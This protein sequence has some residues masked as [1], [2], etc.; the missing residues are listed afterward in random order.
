MKAINTL[1]VICLMVLGSI[2]SSHS[3]TFSNE[4]ITL[5]NIDGK[6]ITL[7]SNTELHIT[8]PSSS[9]TGTINITSDSGWLF[10]EGVRPSEAIENHLSYIKVNGQPSV[11]KNNI[12]VTNFLLGCV[13]MNHAP[14]F[15]ALSAFK[16][17]NYSGEEMRFSP[18]TYYKSV[19]LG[20]FDNSISS[21]KL[22]RGYMATF[23]ENENG[24]GYSKVFI[25]DKEDIE[26]SLLQVELNNKVSFIRVFPWRYTNKKGIGSGIDFDR[27]SEPINRLNGG[28]FYTWR[29]ATTEDL[30]DIEFV[31]M[32]WS[33]NSHTDPR[34]Q[35]IVNLTE[36]NHLLGFNE[37]DSSGHADM[38]LDEMIEYWPKMMESGLRLGSP[39]PASL[40]NGLL[41]DFI[42][43]CD[44]LNYRVDFVAIHDYRQ[45]SAND[46][47]LKA[48]E[49]H[50]RTGRPIWVT[51]FNYGGTWQAGNPSYD[52]VSARVKEIIEKYDKQGIIERFAIFNFDE[53]HTNRAVYYTPG[54]NYNITPLGEVY[55]DHL[56]S[57]AYNSKPSTTTNN[58]ALNKP[59]TASS[60]YSSYES[61]FAVDGNDSDNASRWLVRFNDNPLP[62]WIEI[63][64]QDSYT[65]NSY[66]IKEAGNSKN[67]ELQYWDEESASWKIGESVTGN[68]D[69]NDYYGDSFQPF[70]TN[71]VRLYITEHNRIDYLRVYEIELYGVES[72]LSIKKH[73]LENT[74]LHPNPA[75]EYVSIELD[76]K[77]EQV[78]VRVVNM[79]GQ[80]VLIKSCF[81]DKGKF[82]LNISDLKSG[83]YFLNI[84][85]EIFQNHK[86]LK[87]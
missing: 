39:A 59:T 36:V 10:L 78:K 46:F 42:D 74:F 65:I 16:E 23:A 63:D 12:R 57:L 79:L 43:K 27:T 19:Q 67:F 3:Q 15:E 11:H 47:Y 58:V 81:V 75:K 52:T 34:W 30:I 48:K 6:N 8:N 2:S 70:T 62:A 68:P 69:N 54:T 60:H 4:I 71:K 13:I 28:W 18:E 31:P 53:T 84:E 61:S 56:S 21:F 82:N 73:V 32:K 9:T 26:V 22:K 66:L 49:A 55:R 37:P 14:T 64:L 38:T 72:T 85:S 50:D 87:L 41:Y 45:T 80:P 25:A 77:Q 51:E 29:Q 17:E 35:E 7:T 33:A 24:T 44:E 5:D 1:F 40:S 83:L 76:T 20:S 86:L